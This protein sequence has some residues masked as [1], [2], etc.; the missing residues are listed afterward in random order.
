MPPRQ[1]ATSP[2]QRLLPVCAHVTALLLFRRGYYGAARMAMSYGE[3]ALLQDKVAT[4][5]L[6]GDVMSEAVLMALARQVVRSALSRVMVVRPTDCL[7]SRDRGSHARDRRSP[8]GWY[9]CAAGG[10]VRERLS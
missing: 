3:Y 8:R 10:R 4:R 7:L 5:R 6:D 9:C 2:L 1:F